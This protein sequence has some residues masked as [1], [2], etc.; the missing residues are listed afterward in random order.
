MEEYSRYEKR[1]PDGVT[2][3]R[4]YRPPVVA[5]SEAVDELTN[6]IYTYNPNTSS[7]EGALLN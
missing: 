3:A 4:A 2:L 5:T 7:W 1:S 6:L